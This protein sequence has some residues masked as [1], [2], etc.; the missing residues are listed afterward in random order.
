METKNERTKRYL[1]ELARDLVRARFI[2]DRDA[3]RAEANRRA[4]LV[5][6]IGRESARASW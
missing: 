5:A 2:R 3:V 1:E 4:R 6:L